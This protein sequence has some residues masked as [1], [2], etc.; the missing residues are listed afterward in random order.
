MLLGINCS[1]GRA[2]FTA[3]L[4]VY[5][6]ADP[7]CI[8]GSHMADDLRLGGDDLQLFGF[9]AI[10]SCHRDRGLTG[11][12]LAFLLCSLFGLNDQNGEPLQGAILLPEIVSSCFAR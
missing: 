9:L 6:L 11:R 3:T 12:L 1:A 7:T 5:P 10:V 4:G 8:L 2:I